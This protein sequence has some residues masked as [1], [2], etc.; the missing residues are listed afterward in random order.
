M[1]QWVMP[2]VC[3]V[4]VLIL[5]HPMEVHHAKNTARLLHLSLSGSRLMVAE[6]FEQAALQQALS[7]D[8]LNLLLYPQA[9]QP[10]PSLPVWSPTQRPHAGP[11]RLVVLDATWRKSRK[12][13]YLNPAL[14]NLQRLSLDG[15]HHSRYV[16]RK[17]H[18]PGQL[19]TLEATC[20]ALAQLVGDAA[21]FRPLLNAMDLFM[22]Q[23]LAFQAQPLSGGARSDNRR[24]CDQSPGIR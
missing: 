11:V 10:V 16:I 22:A 19:S 8:A 12:M 2:V 14:Q 18:K 24:R 5:Q 7:G 21:P 20:A 4:E 3:P 17:A 13:L 9:E 15:A 23:R 6:Q 1:C